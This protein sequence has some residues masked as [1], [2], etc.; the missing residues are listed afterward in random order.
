MINHFNVINNSLHTWAMVCIL[1]A[2][3]ARPQ[4]FDDVI[5]TYEYGSM[6]KYRGIFIMDT[7]ILKK[8]TP[9]KPTM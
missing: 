6:S 7:A 3:K 5:P 2:G 8:P 1:G 4:I 9:P